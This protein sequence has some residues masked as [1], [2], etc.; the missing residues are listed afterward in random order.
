MRMTQIY[1]LTDEAEKF[2]KENVEMIPDMVCTDCGK[3]M[4]YKQNRKVYDDAKDAGMFGD[5]PALCEYTLKLEHSIVREKLNK[6]TPWS[7]GPNLFIDLVDQN[8]NILYG[9]SE[10][11]INKLI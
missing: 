8:G 9:W 10:E 2:I 11:E 1:G 3:V 6:Y 7:S 5:G 4:S